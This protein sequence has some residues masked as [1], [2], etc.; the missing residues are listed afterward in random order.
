MIKKINKNYLE[1]LY[2][3]FLGIISSFSLPPYNYWFI[4]FF[5]F[6]LLFVFLL[7]NKNNNYKLF[8]VYG[9]IFGFGYFISNL[10]WIPLSLLHDNDLKILIPIAIILIPAFLSLFYSFAF[11]T[12]K[13][14]LNSKSTFINILSFSLVLS[15][16]EFIRGTVLSGF[17]WNLFAYSLSENIEFIQITSLIGIFTFN[18]ILITIYVSPSILFLNKKKIDLLGFFFVIILIVSNYVY[19]S[20]KV[21]NF[22][23]LK[24][25][26]L[27]AEIKV[28]STSIPI[29]RFY[30]NID[31]EKILIKLIEMSS[32]IQNKN[33]IFIWP[34]GVIPNINLKNLKDEYYYLFKKSFFE[35]H[36]II[37]GINDDQIQNEKKFFYNS[38]SIIDNEANAVYKYYKN[39]LVPFGEFLPLENV[40]SKIGLKSL[41][42]NYQSYTPDTNRTLFD[43]GKNNK[44]KILPLICYEIIYSGN[45]S[46]DNDYNFIVN[47]SEDGWFGESI[48]PYQHFAHS[49][50]RSVEYGKYT[51]R[52]SNNGI[53]A[54]IDPS[55]SIINKININKEG[56]ISIKEIV[57]VDKTFFSIYGNKIYFCIILLYI[58]LIFSFKKLENE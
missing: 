52:S 19:G 12:F 5:S 31:E 28:L 24:T 21:K 53:S 47:I 30:S 35:N 8:F 58:F 48:G 41:T 10:Y 38:L 16:F 33:T 36:K 29:E 15:L 27:P 1:K 22:Q 42:N 40:L 23:N 32:P 18:T 51:L 14:L 2:I 25:E 11:L 57:S 17:P 34:E 50:F 6:S 49:I 39:K 37:L 46:K 55:G 7:K 45:L 20:L 13:L 56:V 4:C 43:F 9:Y 54:I 26:I 3:L 44:I